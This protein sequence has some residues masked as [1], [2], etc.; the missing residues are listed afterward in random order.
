MPIRDPLYLEECVR[1]LVKAS[2]LALNV[3]PQPCWIRDD[4]TAAIAF[5]RPHADE[6][7]G[8][9]AKEGAGTQS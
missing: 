4:L 5:A 1:R 3:M 2:R 8:L 9:V 6:A 7:Q